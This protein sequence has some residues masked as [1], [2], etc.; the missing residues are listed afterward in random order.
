MLASALGALLSAGADAL[1]LCTTALLE[2]ADFEAALPVPSA[3]AAIPAMVALLDLI[4]S[5]LIAHIEVKSF[6]KHDLT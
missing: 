3:A 5:N 4:W 6:I 1:R 2:L